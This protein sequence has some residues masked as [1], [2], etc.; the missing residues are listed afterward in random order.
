MDCDGLLELCEGNTS[1]PEKC[2]GVVEVAGSDPALCVC[3]RLMY[4]FIPKSHRWKRG[5]FYVVC[6]DYVRSLIE[7]LEIKG[8]GG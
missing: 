3:L 6:M 1:R 4:R 5:S 8:G 2:K 7:S